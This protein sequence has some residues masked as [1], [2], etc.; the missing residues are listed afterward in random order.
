MSPNEKL[1]KWI[2]K[3]NQDGSALDEADRDQMCQLLCES[4]ET[5][6]S[7]LKDEP[8]RD[9]ELPKTIVKPMISR[10]IREKAME[11]ACQKIAGKDQQAMLSWLEGVWGCV[12]E[13]PSIR[14][15]MGP[16][17]P[18]VYF[19]PNDPCAERIC[20]MLDNVLDH[21]DL[22][23][24]T[25]TD[26]RLT[27]A[28]IAA[29]RREVQIRLITD[30]LKSNDL[31]SDIERL[32]SEGIPI[33]VD[34]S[35]YH[36]HHKFAIFDKTRLLTGSYNWTRN[37]SEENLENLVVTSDMRIVHAFIKEF[38]RLWVSLGSV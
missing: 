9:I 26:N 29:H 5:A 10:M 16:E 37:A 22:C 3:K 15:Q 33:K 18:V 13:A 34:R 2:E 30:D 4:L 7:E 28:I 27:E 8:S 25:I 17:A 19:S 23:V 21:L 36:M 6:L 32:A 1:L 38:E 11:L 14:S 24:F 20:R 12:V 31:G 35:P